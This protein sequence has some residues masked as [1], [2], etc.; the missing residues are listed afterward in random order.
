MEKMRKEMSL[1]K[2]IMMM[3]TQTII[4]INTKDTHNMKIA[5]Q[6]LRE[7]ILKVNQALNNPRK[8]KKGINVPVHIFSRCKKNQMPAGNQIALILFPTLTQSRKIKTYSVIF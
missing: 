6:K 5:T 8:K 2:M 1:K 7:N 4:K 3:I